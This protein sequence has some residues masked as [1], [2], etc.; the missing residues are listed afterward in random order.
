[1]SCG[2]GQQ[3]RT[4]NCLKG[5]CDGNVKMARACNTQPCTGEW[6]CWG[7][8]SECSVTCGVGKKSRKRTCLAGTDDEVGCE[9]PKTE[10]KMCEM[11]VCDC[12]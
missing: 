4:K 3:Y 2:G 1:M 8:W 11:P 7:E 9:G 10:T 12:E 5:N 6:G